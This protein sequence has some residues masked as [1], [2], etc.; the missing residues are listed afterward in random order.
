[1]SVLNIKFVHN[2]LPMLYRYTNICRSHKL[3]DT[4]L[5]RGTFNFAS[6]L[7]AEPKTIGAIVLYEYNKKECI[8]MIA[9]ARDF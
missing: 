1:M 4:R 7:S 9:L 5:I 8:N 3:K 2:D 6:L